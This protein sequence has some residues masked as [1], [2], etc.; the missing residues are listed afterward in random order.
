MN[1]PEYPNLLRWYLSIASRPAVQRGYNVP[2]KVED[3]PIP[4]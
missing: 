2:K 3:I 4:D 1:L